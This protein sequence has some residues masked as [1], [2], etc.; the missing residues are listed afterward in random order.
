MLGLEGWGR[1][2]GVRKGEKHEIRM[3]DGIRECAATWTG[4]G[5]VRVQQLP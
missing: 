1:G 5:P 3:C 2:V 4:T